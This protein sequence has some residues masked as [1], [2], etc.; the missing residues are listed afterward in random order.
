MSTTQSPGRGFA[1]ALSLDSATLQAPT[2]AALSSAVLAAEAAG[3]DAVL[4]PDRITEAP[5]TGATAD[6]AA[7]TGAR[8]APVQRLDAALAAA[9]LGPLAHSIG[10]IPQITSAVTEPFHVA[11]AL[12]TID[13]A[14]LGRAGLALRPGLDPAERAAVNIWEPTQRPDEAAERAAVL[15][16]AVDSLEAIERLWDS[17]EEDAIIRDVAT[18]RFL[19]RERIHDAAYTGH[20]FSVEGASITPRSPQGRPPVLVRV[21]DEDELPLAAHADIVVLAADATV[22]AEQVRAAREHLLLWAELPLTRPDALASLPPVYDGVLLAPAPGSPLPADLSDALAR[23]VAAAR[24]RT[25]ERTAAEATP[26]DHT[27]GTV[28]AS[29]HPTLRHR[30]SLP[31]A[32]N[33]YTAARHAE[34]ATHV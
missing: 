29:A 20:R 31:E 6:G 30:L 4:L 34:E 14:S 1:V 12:Q 19:D 25:T 28:S 15:Q 10:L 26:A 33:P 27:T 2:L 24:A 11:T 21:R 17:W 22:G 7:G 32:V 3:V 8:Q 5:A 9:A 18:G 23:A 13:H 16:D